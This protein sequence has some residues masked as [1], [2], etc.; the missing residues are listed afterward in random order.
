MHLRLG[1][2]ARDHAQD[3]TSRHRPHRRRLHAQ[4][5]RLQPDPHSKADRGVG[6]CPFI[7]PESASN[8]P[9]SRTPPQPTA[10]PSNEKITIFRFFSRLLETLFSTW[11]S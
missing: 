3:Q 1:Q 6:G 5:D 7:K 10:L 4:S 11:F 9:K 8:E 2:A